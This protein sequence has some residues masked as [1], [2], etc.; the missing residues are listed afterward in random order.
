M[1]STTLRSIKNLKYQQKWR[2]SEYQERNPK[3]P[4]CYGEIH[5]LY[6]NC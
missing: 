1:L 4:K 5:P 3:Y 2:P 6:S